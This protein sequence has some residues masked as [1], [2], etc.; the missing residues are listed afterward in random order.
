V[1]RHLELR[2]ITWDHERGF[3]PLR[4]SALDF[5]KLHPNVSV[6]WDK[7]SLAAFG[8][9]PL[10]VLAAEYDLVIIDHPFCG[11][12]VALDCLVDLSTLLPTAYIDELRADSVGP[13]TDSYA[14]GGGRWALPT[15]AAA[16][17]AAYRNDLLAQLDSS[18][19]STFAEVVTLAKHA[20]RA[21]KFVA[22]PLCKTDAACTFVS[23]LANLGG[24]PKHTPDTSNDTSSIDRNIACEAIEQLQEL[25]LHVHPACVEWSPV[26][27]FEHMQATNEI[28]Y[29][30]FIFGYSNYARPSQVPIHFTDIAGPGPDPRTGAVLGGAGCAISTHCQHPE[31]AA[32]Y[33]MFVHDA[34]YQAETYFESGGQ[35]GR[36]S[37]WKSSRLNRDSNNFFLNTHAT[38]ELSYVRPRF[39]GF[40]PFLESAGSHIRQ[41]LI[42]GG[43]AS[44]LAGFLCSEFESAQCRT[45]KY[46]RGVA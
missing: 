29:V 22:L 7:R 20:R 33:L 19:P 38:L 36:L 6:H 25:A 31:V 12:A 14:L 41:L 30:P 42:A 40:V 24:A 18:V 34:R 26:S 28:V 23:L 27:T 21:G 5:Q 2:G 3:A 32:S 46:Q 8:A 35:P 45:Q 15:D 16:Q 13:S 9:Q 43:S 4:Q 37:A 11:T 10:E 1:T 39:H 44:Q 17:V